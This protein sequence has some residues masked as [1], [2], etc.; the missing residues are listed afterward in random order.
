M[1]EYRN[2]FDKWVA[3]I[4]DIL[5]KI[6]EETFMEGLLPWIKV[7]TEFCRP[8]ELAEMMKYVQMVEN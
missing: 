2:L 7:E 1:E 6:V 8:Q 5:E 3:P 4:S